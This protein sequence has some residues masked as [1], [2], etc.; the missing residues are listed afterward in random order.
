MIFLAILW[1]MEWMVQK[2]EI[3]LR[4]AGWSRLKMVMA[5][6]TVDLMMEVERSE[7]CGVCDRGAAMGLLMPLKGGRRRECEQSGTD[8]QSWTAS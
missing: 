6:I 5:W 8:P 3:S 7:Q 2:E 1:R 4:D